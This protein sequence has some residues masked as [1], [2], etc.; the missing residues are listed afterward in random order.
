MQSTL[1]MPVCVN[2]TVDQVPSN[3]YGA[4]TCLLA[5]LALR[6]CS[7]A[8]SYS[9]LAMRGMIIMDVG[10]ATLMSSKNVDMS[11]RMHEDNVSSHRSSSTMAGSS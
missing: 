7:C 8:W 10:R 9:M 2:C 6:I 1:M 5:P 4:L 11:L 3:P